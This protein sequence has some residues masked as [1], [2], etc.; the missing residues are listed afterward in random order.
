MNWANLPAA[1]QADIKKAA[2]LL[3]GGLLIMRVELTKKAARQLS[4]L[5]EPLKSQIIRAL[6]KLHFRG[7]TNTGAF[8]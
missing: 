2:A 1:Y 6:K 8:R 4:R 3:Q 5:N 7:G